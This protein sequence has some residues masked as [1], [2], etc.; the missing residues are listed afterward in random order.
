MRKSTIR[1]AGYG[2]L[3]NS[4]SMSHIK[5]KHNIPH[6]KVF[7]F[8]D[9]TPLNT[10]GPEFEKNNNPIS[11]FKE[12]VDKHTKI[13]NKRTIQRG[14]SLV[15]RTK[16]QLSEARIILKAEAQRLQAR[17]IVI[18][19]KLKGKAKVHAIVIK[20]FETISQLLE[21]SIDSTRIQLK[22]YEIIGDIFMLYKD[23]ISAALYYSKGVNFNIIIEITF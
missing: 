16:P 17:E 18:S 1:I 2:R 7:K 14:K 20:L 19:N 8:I 12:V 10:K 13:L 11:S 21:L 15:I 5:A 4:H 22:G 6:H 3:A 23:Y 9:F